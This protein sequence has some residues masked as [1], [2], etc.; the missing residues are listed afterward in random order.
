MTKAENDGINILLVSS[1]K[2]L[3][4]KFIECLTNELNNFTLMNKTTEFTSVQDRVNFSCFISDYSIQNENSKYITKYVQLIDGADKNLIDGLIMRSTNFTKNY[5]FYIHAL[6]YLYD[7]SNSDTFA[8]VK[9]IHNELRKSNEAFTINENLTCLLCNMINAANLGTNKS[10]SEESYKVLNQVQSFLDEYSNF[11]YVSQPFQDSILGSKPIVENSDESSNKLRINFDF[12][13]DRY[14]TFVPNYN[15]ESTVM[16]IKSFTHSM[17]SES[18]KKSM[19]TFKKEIFKH[20]Y[21][22][23]M[24]NNLRNGF[25]IYV[26]D[27]NFFR[28]EGEWKDGIK[29]GNGKFIMKDGSFYEGEFN[30]GEMTGKGYKYD[31]N[32]ETEYTGDFVEGHYQ[33]KGVLRCR[34]KYV[35]EGDFDEN[36]KHGYGELNEF[37]INQTYK[38]QWYLNK[39]HGQGSQKYSDGSVYTGDWIRDKR[40]GHGE[41]EYPNGNLYDGQWRNDIMSG[42]GFFKTFFGYSYEGIFDNGLPA[43]LATKLVFDN[44]EGKDKLEIFE[45]F[46]N[47][48]KITVN[49]VNDQNENFKEDCRS[50]QLSFGFKCDITDT[51]RYENDVSTEFGFSYIPIQLLV[52]GEGSK[53]KAESYLIEENNENDDENDNKMKTSNE[54]EENKSE[55]KTI[56]QID[57]SFSFNSKNTSFELVVQNQNG[58]ASFCNLYIDNIKIPKKVEELERRKTARKTPNQTSKTSNAAIKPT[59]PELSKFNINENS[60]NCVLIAEDVTNPPIFGKKLKSTYI[61]CVLFL[62]QSETRR[63]SLKSGISLDPK[64]KSKVTGKK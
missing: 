24:A 54:I 27:N 30:N 15:M 53:F 20:N 5:P 45:G 55:I 16:D 39:R 56:D 63:S 51:N 1:S 17:N 33:G 22:G 8:Y 3:K 4:N 13:V 48:F 41:L 18:I 19:N 32:R 6:V 35:Y 28:Y 60:V 31:K 2:L 25:G 64:T 42:H 37:K 9:S 10:E 50:I 47:Q 44:P 12:L 34:N 61:D 36:M 59:P 7:E 52:Y 38:G 43:N 23:E 57:E 58:E 11:Q 14:F 62:K 29:Q 26:Y 21:K 49:A 46:S 40:Q